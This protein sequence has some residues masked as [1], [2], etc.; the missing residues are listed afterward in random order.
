MTYLADLINPPDPPMDASD[1]QGYQFDNST[2]EGLNALTYVSN[3]TVLLNANFNTLG[4]GGL[5]PT[6]SADGDDV[7]F[8]GDWFVFGAANA[9]YIIT[10][11]VYATNSTIKSASEH[12]VG[13]IVSTATGDPF[14]FY[15]RQ[16]ASLRKYQKDNLTYSM[17]IKNNQSKVIKVRADIFCFFDPSSQ[18][19]TGKPFYLQPG[20][21]Q[22]TSTLLTPSLEGKTVG[23]GSYTEFRFN[24]AD[25]YDGTA[26]IELYQIK[27]EFGTI[28][29]P[30]QL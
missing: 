1:D 27:C 23:A 8:I 14:Y 18:L 26:D 2:Y 7:E 28:G 25:L 30:L 3:P 4:P 5:T 11:T 10:P 13:L 29:T 17:M 15:Q 24:Y 6:V 20:L 12:F 19:I 22:V 9:D 21:N 16:M